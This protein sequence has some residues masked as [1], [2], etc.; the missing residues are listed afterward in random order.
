M[1]RFFHYTLL[2]TILTILPVLVTQ[3]A[4]AQEQDVENSDWSVPR[5]ISLGTLGDRPVLQRAPNGDLMAVYNKWVGNTQDG[6]Y[7]PY[8]TIRKNGSTTWSAPALINYQPNTSTGK[9][10][11]FIFD[12]A[13]NAHAVWVED[14]GSPLTSRVRYANKTPNGAWTNGNTLYTDD[15]GIAPI[16]QARIAAAPNGNLYVVWDTFENVYYKRSTNGGTSWS[17]ETIVQPGGGR[18]PAMVADANSNI[19]IAWEQQSTAGQF[20]ISYARIA[21]GSTTPST[22]VV[23]N[24]DA[25]KINDKFFYNQPEIIVTATHIHVSYIYVNGADEQEQRVFVKRCSL[26]QD[27]TQQ[28]NWTNGSNA[29]G[30]FLGVNNNAPSSILN[31]LS[32][33]PQ[34]DIV[35]GFYHGFYDPKNPETIPSE[36]LWLVD[37]CSSGN[38]SKVKP[39]SVELPGQSEST[40]HTRPSVVVYGDTAHL[41]Y[42]SVQTQGVEDIYKIYYTE[43]PVK[44]RV[45][46]LYLPIIRA[47]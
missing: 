38:W 46:D 9:T 3:Y 43:A 17:A 11:Y 13:S 32:H 19:H 24:S 28:S 25:D 45:A 23:I 8:Y 6:R 27:C 21:N 41:V 33:D 36:R 39:D 34:T 14:Q 35:H 30:G 15:F 42:E 16:E 44:C 37:S 20:V 7:E 26:S 18:L 31:S 4:N 1:K 2:L 5:E 29:S 12:S 10:V 22:P 40:R 47:K